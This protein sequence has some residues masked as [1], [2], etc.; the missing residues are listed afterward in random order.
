M[1]R[2]TTNSFKSYGSKVL[3]PETGIFYNNQMD[4]FS[5]PNTSNQFGVPA[6]PANYI[7]PAKRPVSSISPLIIWDATKQRV[8]QV[9]GGSGGTRIT[10][11]VAQVAIRN[12]LFKQDIKSAIDAPRLHSQLLPPEVVVEQDFDEVRINSN[13]ANFLL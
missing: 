10:T 3:G 12:W 1:Y 2:H 5:T 9:L 6:S 7:A 4:S 11:S 8:L 13:S